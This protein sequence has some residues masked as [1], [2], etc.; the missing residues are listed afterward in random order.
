MNAELHPFT[1]GELTFK[2]ASVLDRDIAPFKLPAFCPTCIII[3]KVYIQNGLAHKR[4]RTM[5]I[6]RISFCSDSTA[7]VDELA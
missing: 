7:I 5:T 3:Q 2:S 4:T 1:N 6:V